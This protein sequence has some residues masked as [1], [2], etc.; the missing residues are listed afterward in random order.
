VF[1]KKLDAPNGLAE[2]MVP[3][4]HCMALHG[5]PINPH[6]VSRFFLYR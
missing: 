6:P 2:I 5:I 1:A 4:M 3:S